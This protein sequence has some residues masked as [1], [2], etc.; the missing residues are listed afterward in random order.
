MSGD[1]TRDRR[2]RDSHELPMGRTLRRV[3]VI[4]TRVRNQPPPPHIVFDELVR[5]AGNPTRPWLALLDDEVPPRVTN[6]SR[7]APVEW[8]SLWAKRPDLVLRFVLAPDAGGH[9]TDLRWTLLAG[10]P[11][12]ADALIGHLR[13][14]VNVLINADLRYSFGQ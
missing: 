11:V 1:D 4:G 12:P 10:E 8:S 14:R 7:P 5:A 2:Q 3:I 13:K 9:G 6:S